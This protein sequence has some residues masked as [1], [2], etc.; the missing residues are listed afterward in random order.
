MK[1]NIN[2][3]ILINENYNDGIS[4]SI[5]SGFEK[6]NQKSIAAIVCLGDMP[7]INSDIYNS[8]LMEHQYVI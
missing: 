5:K 4:S 8:E 2:F 7:M 1:K 3:L 6:I